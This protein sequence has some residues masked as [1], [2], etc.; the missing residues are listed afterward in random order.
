MLSCIGLYARAC[1]N[2]MI[3]IFFRFVQIDSDSNVPVVYLPYL[4]ISVSTI[5]LVCTNVN[6]CASHADRSKQNLRTIEA[7]YFSS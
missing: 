2:Y 4:P 6:D 7:L 1:I 5:I 3:F